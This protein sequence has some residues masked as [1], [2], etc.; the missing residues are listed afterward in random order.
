M[1]ECE[2]DIAL[3]DFIKFHEPMFKQVEPERCNVWQLR[4]GI[5]VDI[6]KH[7]LLVMCEGDF[8]NVKSDSIYYDIH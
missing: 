8:F 5:I 4:Y 7:S 6:G 2:R 1:P 3:G